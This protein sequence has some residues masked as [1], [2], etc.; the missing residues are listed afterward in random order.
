MKIANTNV[1]HALARVLAEARAGNVEAVAIIAVAPD[2][3]PDVSF[4]GEA[5]LMPSANVGL[6]LLKQ[7]FMV[8]VMKEMEKPVSKVM[9]PANGRLD[10]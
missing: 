8:R 3:V 9:M 6:D 5:E 2:G 7:S 4:G 1:V 10:G